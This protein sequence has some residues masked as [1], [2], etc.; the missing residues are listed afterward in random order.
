MGWSKEIAIITIPSYLLMVLIALV[1][2][3]VFRN[4]SEKVK[5]IPIYVLS[6]L[7]LIMEIGKQ[8]EQIKIGYKFWTL[9]L[10]FCSFFMVWPLFSMFGKG[11]VKRFGDNITFIFGLIIFI[12]ML[13]NPESIYGEAVYKLYYNKVLTHSFVF[14]EIVVFIVFLYVALGLVDFNKKDWCFIPIALTFYTIIV[15]PAAYLLNTNYCSVLRCEYSNI[16]ETIRLGAGQAV[17]DIFI[18]V[19][20]LV[21]MLIVHFTLCLL[22]NLIKKCRNN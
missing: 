9:P 6:V 12:L 17:Y 4:K 13:I 2:F 1:L 16:L 11:R 10:H 22:T 5:Y 18:F 21:V 7:L 15:V 20:A 19:L 8:I 3:F 14:H